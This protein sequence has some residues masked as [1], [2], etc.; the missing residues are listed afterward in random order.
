MKFRVYR[1]DPAKDSAPYMKDYDVALDPQVGLG[2][3]P[4]ARLV[5][6]LTTATPEPRPPAL[7]CSA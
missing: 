3:D 1:Y 4:F 2:H 7:C 6:M 5:R